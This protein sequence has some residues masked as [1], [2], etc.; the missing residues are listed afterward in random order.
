[1]KAI[2]NFFEEMNEFVYV[3]DIENNELVYMN[4]KTRE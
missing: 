4:K 1:M 3:S 2:W